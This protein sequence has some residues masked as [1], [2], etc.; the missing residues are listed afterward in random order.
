MLTQV[1]SCFNQSSLEQCAIEAIKYNPWEAPTDTIYDDD[2]WIALSELFASG[3]YKLS[4]LLVG[5]LKEI[6]ENIMESIAQLLYD[7]FKRNVHLR[8]QR[9]ELERAVIAFLE[10]YMGCLSISP[11]IEFTLPEKGVR[12]DEFKMLPHDL[13]LSHKEATILFPVKF[14]ISN[15]QN[16]IIKP[17]VMCI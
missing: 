7:T 6:T 8:D 16:V 11:R 3:K 13:G 15:G 12:M 14:G 1:Q 2:V 9:A 4:P 10:T 5:A 17:T